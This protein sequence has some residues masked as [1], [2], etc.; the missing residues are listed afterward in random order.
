ML[1]ACKDGAV[2]AMVL[3]ANLVLTAK[4]VPN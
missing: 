3:T 4:M 2:T 1:L